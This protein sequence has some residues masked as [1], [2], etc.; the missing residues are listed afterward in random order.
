VTPETWAKAKPLIEAAMR[1]GLPTHTAE[2]VRADIDAGKQQLWCMGETAIVTE[3]VTFPRL[4]ACRV[5]YVAGRMA[6]VEKMKPD[7]ENWARAEGCAFMLAGGRKGWVRTLPDYFVT[8][9][10]LAKELV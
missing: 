4:K 8:A 1:R 9:H 2:D 5:V 6:D 10:S 7:I 3:V